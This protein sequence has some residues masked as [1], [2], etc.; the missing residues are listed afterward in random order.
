[1]EDNLTSYFLSLLF[2]G[3]VLTL[4]TGIVDLMYYGGADMFGAGWILIIIS[5]VATAVAV[6]AWLVNI[7]RQQPDYVL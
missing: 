2:S 7:L 6:A 4:A 1:M 3:I 5:A